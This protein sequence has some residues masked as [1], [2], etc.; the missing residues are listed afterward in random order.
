MLYKLIN[1]LT[2]HLCLSLYID[3]ADRA[4]VFK[5]SCEYSKATVLYHF[6]NIAKLHT[7]AC[8]RL[9]R[10]KSVHSLLPRH[11]LKRNLNIHIYDLFKKVL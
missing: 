1:L 7:K 2:R 10:T 5:S 9:V 4:T 8:I 6:R 3:T 11:T